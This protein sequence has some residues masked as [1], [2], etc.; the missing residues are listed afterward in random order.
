MR[1]DYNSNNNANTVSPYSASLHSL[2]TSLYPQ[3]AMRTDSESVHTLVKVTQPV[4]GRNEVRMWKA[5]V[6][7]GI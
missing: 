6:G 2:L 3:T 7:P 1:Y 5:A 4:K